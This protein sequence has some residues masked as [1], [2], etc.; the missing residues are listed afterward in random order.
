MIESNHKQKEKRAKFVVN[1]FMSHI[2]TEI[3]FYQK[4]MF[5]IEEHLQMLN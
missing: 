2:R 3:D 1:T 4:E 5:D